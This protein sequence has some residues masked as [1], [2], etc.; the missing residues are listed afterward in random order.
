MLLKTS[1]DHGRSF[2][3]NE[4]NPKQGLR[5]WCSGS[6]EQVKKK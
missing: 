4:Q 5:S 6:N 2:G 3:S 1:I